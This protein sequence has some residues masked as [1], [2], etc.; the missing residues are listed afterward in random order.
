[1]LKSYLVQFSSKKKKKKKKKKS[2]LKIFTIFSQK[3]VFL[4]FREVQLSCPEIKKQFL[5]FHKKAF[6]IYLEMEINLKTYFISRGAFQARKRIIKKRSKKI[7]FI[8][9]NGAF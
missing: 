6:L 7:S 1:M 8:S 4:I 3:K 9:G 5:Y 2:A